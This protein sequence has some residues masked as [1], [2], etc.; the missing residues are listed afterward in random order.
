[1]NKPDPKIFTIDNSAPERK[2]LHC[3]KQWIL[4]SKA[5]DITPK[6]LRILERHTKERSHI[7]L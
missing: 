4:A 7:Y 6:I 3:L 2:V 5:A 1:M